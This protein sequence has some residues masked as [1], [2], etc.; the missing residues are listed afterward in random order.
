M[1]TSEVYQLRGAVSYTVMA[2]LAPICRR[3]GSVEKILNGGPG[4]AQYFG[5]TTVPFQTT[6]ALFHSTADA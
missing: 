6:S 3:I 5:F 4:Q 2:V 1:G